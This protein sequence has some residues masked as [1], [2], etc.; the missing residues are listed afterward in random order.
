MRHYRIEGANLLGNSET[1]LAADLAFA[2]LMVTLAW[3]GGTGGDLEGKAESVEQVRQD[4]G[5]R[6][7]EGREEPDQTK[8]NGKP[9]AMAGI[10]SARHLG[11]GPSAP[12]SGPASRNPARLP[13]AY[14]GYRP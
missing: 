7:D 5:G 6:H 1:V 11:A 4:D 8:I 2:V 12:R 9:L 14:G 13:L 3:A 10:L